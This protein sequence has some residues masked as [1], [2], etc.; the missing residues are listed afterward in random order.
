MDGMEY[1]TGWTGTLS[2]SQHQNK[3][4]KTASF[5]QTVTNELEGGEAS[6]QLTEVS[7][8]ASATV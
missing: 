4:H 6:Q 2:Y 3:T 7:S 8:A 1:F 5:K